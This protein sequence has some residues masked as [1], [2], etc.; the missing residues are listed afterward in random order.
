VWSEGGWHD[1]ENI[2]ATDDWGIIV[3]LKR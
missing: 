3:E 2:G 1:V